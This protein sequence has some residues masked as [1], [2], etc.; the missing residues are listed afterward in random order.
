MHT[1]SLGYI[2]FSCYH[3]SSHAADV[4]GANVLAR[5]HLTVVDDTLP[6]IIRIFGPLYAI[7]VVFRLLIVLLHS[8]A[9]L[10]VSLLLP[11]LECLL[12]IQLP[13]LLFLVLLLHFFI[14]LSLPVLLL[15]VDPLYD[16]QFL[17]SVVVMLLSHHGCA[18]QIGLHVHL[19][20]ITCGGKWI[21]GSSEGVIVGSSTEVKVVSGWLRAKVSKVVHAHFFKL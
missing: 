7:L 5:V 13:L 18:W 6:R 19:H 9:G 11:V 10:H 14:Q 15:L 2:S 20:T 16:L 17:W 1:T 21:I 8:T 12:S 4:L 3:G